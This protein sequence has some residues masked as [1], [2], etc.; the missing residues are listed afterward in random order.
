MNKHLYNKIVSALSGKGLYSALNLKKRHKIEYQ[1]RSAYRLLS[2]R[3]EGSEKNL[4]DDVE[5]ILNNIFAQY[6][7]QANQ[8]HEYFRLFADNIIRFNKND[9][10]TDQYGLLID[11]TKN[12]NYQN[13]SK[14]FLLILEYMAIANGMY[15]LGYKIRSLIIDKLLV[16]SKQNHV[17]PKEKS[18]FILTLIEKEDFPQVRYELNRLPKRSINYKKYD[19]LKLHAAIMMGERD[20]ALAMAPKYYSNEDKTFAEYIRGKRIAIVGPA[21]TDERQA[22]K[23]MDLILLSELIIAESHLCHQ[24][25]TLAHLLIYLFI[26]IL[27]Q[28][29]F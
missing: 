23:L 20:L 16:E 27:M 11:S 14:Q 6:Q 3:L 9:Y 15:Y 1:S 21:P 8:W 2:Q 5:L 19:K 4:S 13:Q 26:A 24:Y 12:I 18:A 29:Y 10:S 17:T 22:E 25:P 28:K 7:S